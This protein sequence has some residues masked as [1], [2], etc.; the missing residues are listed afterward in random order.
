VQDYAFRP[1]GVVRSPFTERATAPRQP[2]V[3]QGI[4][5]R[6]ELEAGRGFEDALVGLDAWDY[7]WVLFVFHQ[8]VE[9]ARGWRPKVQPPRADAKVGVFAT[10]SPHRPN[11]IG[12]SAVKIVRVLGLVV[13]VRDLD[14]LD[15]TPVLD[16]KPYVPYADAHP[17]ARSGWLEARDP[18]PAWTV[19]FSGL[20]LAQLTW[21]GERGV[22]LRAGIEGALSLG[23]QP[24]AYRRIRPYAGGLRLALKEWRVDF[25]VEARTLTVLTLRSGYRP[26]QLESD[27]A[28]HLHRDFVATFGA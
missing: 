23:P 12:L 1:I 5:G 14:L 20:S 10:R 6:I 27:A 22:D 4:E 21:L 8:N 26:R 19:A 17:D 2:V 9:Q 25:T 11:P 13:H 15:G 3:A 24:H 7:A 16:L 18:G 28:L